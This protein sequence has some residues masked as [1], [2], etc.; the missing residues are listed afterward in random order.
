MRL[1]PVALALAALAGSRVALADPTEASSPEGAPAIDLRKL[2]EPP[3]PTFH[4]LGTLFFGDG[5]RFNNP[6]RLQ[7]Q[8]GESAKTVSVTAPYVTFGV[9]LTIG[10]AF[11]FQHGA[12]LSITGS[13]AGVGQ[14]VTAPTYAISYRGTSHRFLAFG[15]LGPAIITEQDPNV[16][17]ELGVGGAVFVTAGTAFTAELIGNLFY[18]AATKETG[19][20]VY[21][22]LSL[23]LGLLLDQEVLP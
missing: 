8:L 12:W 22:V 7:T 16:G 6:Y 9:A 1:L 19:Y 3:G 11:G 23:Q 14:F 13:L 4:I 2:R 10:D 15:R 18:G 20:P 17:A 21:P 5:L